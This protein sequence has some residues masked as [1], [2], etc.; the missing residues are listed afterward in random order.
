MTNY[1]VIESRDP[2]E[3]RDTRFVEE[4]AII[5]QYEFFCFYGASRDVTRRG[6]TGLSPSLGRLH[7]INHPSRLFGMNSTGGQQ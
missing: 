1:I 6:L 2:F 7:L 3:S 5:P 4:T